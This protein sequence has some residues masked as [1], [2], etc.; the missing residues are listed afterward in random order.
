MSVNAHKITV[1]FYV[2]DASGLSY[3]DFVPVLHSWIQNHSVPD[4][5][6][7]DVADY[8]H[9][10]NGPGTLLV[11]LEANFYLDK[12]DGQ[13]GLTYSRK[14]PADGTFADRLRQAFVACLDACARLQDEPKLAGRIQ[15]RTDE[16]AVRI[17]DRLHAPNTSATFEAVK[18]ELEQL[19][20]WLYPGATLDLE[21]YQSDKTLF[22]VR[23][24]S[25]QSA[26]VATLLSRLGAT[27]P[28]R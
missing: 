21:H 19:L 7:I 1:K 23:I 27:A 13:L 12:L 17:N 11:A 15:F 8:A 9:A 25:D 2:E 3:E 14:T 18:P 4:H 6:L 28:A 24:R 26:D 5:T 16:C 22:E 10:H 20:A